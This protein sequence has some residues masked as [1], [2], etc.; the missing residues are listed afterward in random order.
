MFQLQHLRAE[1]VVILFYVCI[2]KPLII[3]RHKLK[4]RWRKRIL[5][6]RRDCS[7]HAQLEGAFDGLGENGREVSLPIQ[8]FLCANGND[9]IL[10]FIT[11][12]APTAVRK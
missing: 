1:V 7:N 6:K 3:V 11:S 2:K 5:Y 4:I 10:L 9:K 12:Q 8:N